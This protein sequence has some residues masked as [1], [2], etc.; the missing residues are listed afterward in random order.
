[1]AAIN[2]SRGGIRETKRISPSMQIVGTLRT[3]SEVM[4]TSDSRYLILCSRQTTIPSNSGATFFTASTMYWHG[5]QASESSVMMSTMILSAWPYSR[6]SSRSP[7]D[8]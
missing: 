4:N 6:M 2:W 7:S 8:C 3:I 1:M 5:A